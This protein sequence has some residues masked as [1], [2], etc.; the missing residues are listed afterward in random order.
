M[1]TKFPCWAWEGKFEED[2]FNKLKE[3]YG[4]RVVKRPLGK[5]NVDLGVVKSTSVGK[6]TLLPEDIDIFVEVKGTMTLSGKHFTDSQHNTHLPVGIFQIMR[7]IVLPAQ[8]GRLYLPYNRRLE[9]LL[10]DAK[11]ML[12]KTGIR[13]FFYSEKNGFFEWTD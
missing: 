6:K 12:T 7:R 4:D 11:F 9:K 10:E 13:I 3:E 8:E 5:Q 2:V 1:E